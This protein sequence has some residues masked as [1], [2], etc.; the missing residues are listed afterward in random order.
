MNLVVTGG[1]GYIG[2]VVA[3][4]AV[5]SGH[6][7]TVIDN[8][9]CGHRAAVP[10]RADFVLGSVGDR[11]LLDRVFAMRPQ[12][13]VLHLAAEAAIAP[14]VTDPA[15]YFGANLI[16]GA[17][18]IEAMRAFGVTKLVFSSTAA[19]YG[20][21]IALPIDED[22]PQAPIN[23]YGESKLMFERML[24]W[25]HRAYGFSVVCF[26]YFNAA[27]ASA[28]RGEARPDETH[29][30]PLVLDVA[31]GRRQAVTIH[32]ADYPTPDGTCVRDFVHVVD[33][34]R[35]HLLALDRLDDIG[36]DCVNLGSETGFSV[37]QVVDAVRRATSHPVP[38]VEGPRRLGDPA[39]LVA[40]AG[41]A[42]EVL[43]W[44]R[45]HAGL[46]DI[47]ESAWRWRR[48]HPRGY[49]E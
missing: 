12:Q 49:D 30:L 36:F 31:L 38:A 19:I 6:R 18:L 41:R 27:G 26:R 20:E 2:S 45:V 39:V 16:E 9:S 32:G 14:S 40:T 28:T 25:Y 43:G 13:A 46:E 15:R 34:A 48:D 29:L 1:A 8:L 21:P 37:R 11:H 35:A 22:H 3:E 17:A 47:V 33:I 4:L 23:A 7:V 10:P 24:R 42:R 44:H 5:A